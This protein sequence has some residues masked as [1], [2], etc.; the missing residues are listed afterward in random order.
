MELRDY[1]LAMR[2]YWR[3][4][5]GVTLAGLLVAGIVVLATP[6]TYQATAQVFVASTGEGTSGS[7]FVNER[8]TSYPEV[9][10]S[11]TVLGSVIQQ[12]GL[13]ESFDSLR[14]R[15]AAV[16]PP[17]TSQVEI[18]V[19]GPDAQLAA[20]VANAVANRFGTVVEQLEQPPGKDSPVDLTVTNPA[21]VPT[22]PSSPQS[23][24]LLALGLAVG[25]AL[26][27]AAAVVRSRV[28]TTVRTVADV[29]AAWDGR[30]I[31]VYARPS[32][33][34]RRSQL[35]GRPATVL[36]RRLEGMA[37]E[38]SVTALLLS[39]SP[40]RRLEP[41]SFAAEVAA[42]LEERN[43]PTTTVAGTAGSARRSG[44]TLSVGTPLAPMGEWRRIAGEVDAVVLVAEPGRVQC[45]E[46][47]EVQ[48]ILSA[49]GIAPLAVVLPGGRRRRR[50]SA[51][52]DVPEESGEVRPQPRTIDQPRPVP[53][54]R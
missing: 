10:R 51:A 53:A 49:A 9:A 5:V 39:P 41:H 3:T 32:G 46:L 38:G 54:G 30:P 45:A 17:D 7:Q 19:S 34:A 36:A 52:R 1:L 50:S 31:P 28:D 12:L 37:Q 16:N 44:V 42:R 11:R 35:V 8:V 2:R 23:S 47:S 24:L 21:T 6:R 14:A 18:T 29:R 26:G 27:A 48:A 13:T 40:S 25:L 43:V 20:D 15:V 4:W 22:S 33:R